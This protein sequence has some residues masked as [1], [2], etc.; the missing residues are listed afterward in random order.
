M[1]FHWSLSDC[2]SPQFSRIL[3]SISHNLNLVWTVSVHP[4]ISNPSIPLPSHWGYFRVYQLQLVSPSLSCSI[5]FLVLWQGLSTY[6]SFRFLWFSLGGSLGWYNPLYGKFPV[7]GGLFFYYYYLL[8]ESFSH[9]LKLMVFHWSLNDNT[10]PQVS[11][12]LL[13]ILADLNS[14]VVWMVSTRLVLLLILWW[15]YQE[16]QL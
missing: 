15:L 4:P 7:F 9:Q 2:K 13:S 1:V 10:S 5:P 11:S 14:A 12:T 16:H 6:L 3:L 8:F